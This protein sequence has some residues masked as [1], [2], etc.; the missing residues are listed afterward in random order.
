MYPLKIYPIVFAVSARGY[1]LQQIPGIPGIPKVD[2]PVYAD[3][4]ETPFTCTDRGIGFYADTET[5]CQVFHMC[6]A[7]YPMSFI[8]PNG[9][10]FDNSK[11]TC[12]W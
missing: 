4:P 7:D 6:I 10:I 1:V 11:A 3:I 2:Y 12:D 5:G 9:T 8:C